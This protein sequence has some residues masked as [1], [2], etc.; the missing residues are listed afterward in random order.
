M[1]DRKPLVSVIM[2]SLNVV[3][4]IDECIQSVLNQSLKE[5]EIICVD[6]GSTDGTYER[7]KEYETNDSRVRVILSD[8]RSYGYQ[9][10]LGIKESNA[11]YIGIVETDD[12]VDENMFDILYNRAEDNNLD[13]VK[14]DFTFLYDF[15]GYYLYKPAKLF[16]EN[17]NKFYNKVIQPLDCTYLYFHDFNVWKGIYNREFLIE[18]DVMFNESA[19]ASFQDI[20][21]QQLL[22]YYA[23]RCMYIPEKLY[24]YRFGHMTNSSVSPKIL[25][26]VKQEFEH[27]LDNKLNGMTGRKIELI[28]QK[29]GLDLWSQYNVLIDL[30]GS[31]VKKEDVDQCYQWI[32]Q[33]LFIALNNGIVK[34]IDMNQTTWKQITFLLDDKE[35]Y[36]DKYLAM[37]QAKTDRIK[38]K[39]GKI[40]VIWGCGVYGMEALNFCKKYGYDC[41][42]LID[43]NSKLWGRKISG[44][45]VKAPVDIINKKLD[46]KY[47]VA[48]KLHSEEIEMQL[49]KNGVPDKS[50]VIWK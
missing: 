13:F 45:E 31:G 22:L 19:G 18:N 35:A 16:D 29:M 11:K 1:Q 17:T 38:S 3:K 4:Y 8:K 12:Y 50:I 49:K 21:F 2:P 9:V 27:L 30:N 14:A 34:S 47:V 32:K 6:A 33:K 7:L 10:N 48:N 41:I 40:N 39:L 15:D 26:F 37:I 36:T 20:G 23:K 5:I 42:A 25:Q 44:I 46:V 24:Y 28:Y 43:N